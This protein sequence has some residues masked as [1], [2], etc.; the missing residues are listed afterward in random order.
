MASSFKFNKAGMKKLEQDIQK[1]VAGVHIP[2]DGSEDDAVRSVTDQ[3][4]KMGTTPNDAN[5]RKMVRE[6]RGD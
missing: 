6:A 4:K 5:V 2:P 3:L 1:K